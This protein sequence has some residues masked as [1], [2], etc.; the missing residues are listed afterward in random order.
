MTW[1]LL[2]FNLGRHTEWKHVQDALNR[3]LKGKSKI[4]EG[5]VFHYK[6]ESTKL[7]I[8][9][10]RGYVI[11]KTEADYNTIREDYLIIDSFKVHFIPLGMNVEDNCKKVYI[12]GFGRKIASNEIYFAIQALIGRAV[13][14]FEVQIVYNKC[15]SRQMAFVKFK[16][17]QYAR[18][19]IDKSLEIGGKTCN[20]MP[21]TKGYGADQFLVIENA[22]DE[23]IALAKTEDAKR[24]REEEAAT[25]ATQ[26]TG[27]Q[28][29]Q[30][31]LQQQEVERQREL[32]AWRRAERQRQQEVERQEAELQ[33]Q[34]HQSWQLDCERRMKEA[35]EENPSAWIQFL[36][37][38]SSILTCFHGGNAFGGNTFSGGSNLGFDPAACAQAHRG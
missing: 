1:M 2:F 32:A 10:G 11:F 16:D 20:V 5:K 28:R 8:S 25:L 15:I 37:E 17:E 34:R 23:A 18:M 29:Q 13:C 30:A 27:W 24:R 26:D 4:V 35:G 3:R 38:H 33:R 9:T 19:L 6:N 22:K 12:R 7:H 21:Y 31:E 36:N 14:E